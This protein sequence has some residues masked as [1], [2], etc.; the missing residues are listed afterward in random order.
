MALR[1]ELLIR[2]FQAPV[3]GRVSV[4][5]DGIK[6]EGNVPTF[7]ISMDD[8]R[9]Q[10]EDNLEPLTA[11]EYFHAERVREA[12]EYVSIVDQTL[13]DGKPAEWA[14][15]EDPEVAHLL[16]AEQT[17]MYRR[18]LGARSTKSVRWEEQWDF[19]ADA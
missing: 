2:Y 4:P 8:T 1:D 11:D 10:T 12:R 16:V 6:I 15:F 18:D 19:G 14:A 17:D 7:G 9:V 13:V 3:K 5:F